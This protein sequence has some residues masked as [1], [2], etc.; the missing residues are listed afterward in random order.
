MTFLCVSITFRTLRLKIVR[1]TI[2]TVKCKKYFII[3]ITSYQKYKGW[4]FSR[5]NCLSFSQGS[6]I[7]ATKDSL[8]LTL[9]QTFNFH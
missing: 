7:S 5:F 3:E 4:N 6:Q 9:I 8:N 1:E 2:N